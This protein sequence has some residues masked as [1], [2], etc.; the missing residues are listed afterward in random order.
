[1]YSEA[2]VDQTPCRLVASA[3]MLLT[4]PI[5]VHSFYLWESG[6]EPNVSFFFCKAED[7]TCKMDVGSTF[8]GMLREG[9]PRKMERVKLR[10]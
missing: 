6:T 10:G 1:M 9:R 7:G 8:P 5:Q 3:R 4:F 2:G